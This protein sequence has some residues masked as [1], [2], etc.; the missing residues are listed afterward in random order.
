MSKKAFDDLLNIVKSDS[1]KE[2]ISKV[3][4]YRQWKLERLSI[5][6]KK[7]PIFYLSKYF[8]IFFL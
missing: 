4:Q 2:K 1:E 3:K 5:I 8:I 7:V 6:L